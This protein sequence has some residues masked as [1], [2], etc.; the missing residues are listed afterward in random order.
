MAWTDETLEPVFLA[1]RAGVAARRHLLWSAVAANPGRALSAADVAAAAGVVAKDVA[2]DRQFVVWSVLAANPGRGLSANEV[3]ALAGLEPHDVAAVRADLAALGDLEGAGVRAAEEGLWAGDHRTAAGEVRRPVLADG[4]VVVFPVH[5]VAPRIKGGARKLAV[6]TSAA[7]HAYPLRLSHEPGVPL[8]PG[9]TE[10]TYAAR[11]D[12]I[13]VEG[14]F[15]LGVGLDEDEDLPPAR[16]SFSSLSGKVVAPPPWAVRLPTSARTPVLGAEQMRRALRRTAE[17]GR[18]AWEHQIPEIVHGV[19]AKKV[20]DHL[21][22]IRAAGVFDPDDAFQACYLSALKVARGFCSPARPDATWGH[23]LWAPLSRD[24][25]RAMGRGE[26][27]SVSVQDAQRTLFAL[28]IFDLPEGQRFDAARRALGVQQE[29]HRLRRANPGLSEAEA[30]ARVNPEGVEPYQS[31]DIIRRALERIAPPLRLDDSYGDGEEDHH[32]ALAGVVGAEDPAIPGQVLGGAE[33]LALLLGATPDEVRETY[34]DLVAYAHHLRP[35]VETT[36]EQ[37]VAL[38]QREGRIGA[39]DPAFL[40]AP[41]GGAREIGRR[42]GTSAT[43]VRRAYPAV[44]AMAEE[45]RSAGEA[46]RQFEAVQRRVFEA[47]KRG[48]ESWWLAEDRARALRRA[49]ASLTAAGGGVVERES[50]DA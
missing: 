8:P 38:Q 5:V 22:E 23:A 9:L 39:T 50:R 45:E 24:L 14:S 18:R 25:R 19:I 4:A 12:R 15:W 35:D 7:E 36:L 37:L 29:V 40:G 6:T 11:V 27:Q 21:G 43:N 2:S 10:V 31:D 32:N 49:W 41:A 17:R 30:R 44:V 48:A 3:A 28:G 42:L 26:G 33:T 13:V 47:W 46:L 16:A 20:K 34:P 1:V